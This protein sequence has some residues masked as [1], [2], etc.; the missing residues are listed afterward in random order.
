MKNKLVKILF[1]LSVIAAPLAARASL[2]WVDDFQYANGPVILNSEYTPA[3]G[4]VGTNS[5]WVRDSGS[6]F[7]TSDMFTI[8]SNLQ[9]VSTG[10]AGSIISRQDDCFRLLVQTNWALANAGLPGGSGNYGSYTNNLSQPVQVIY[11]SFTV[12]CATSITNIVFTNSPGDIGSSNAVISGIGLPSRYGSY[13]ASFY[14]TF[15]G[16]CGRIQA[17]TNSTQVPNTW[18]LGVT[19]NTLATNL[20]DGGF[21]VDL[22]VNT[23]YQVVEEFDPNP[24]GTQA[25]TIW[26]N[27]ININQTGLHSV[28]T[29][30]T[31]SDKSNSALTNALNAFAFRQASSF[32]NA[33]F[34][35]TNLATA[36]TFAEAMTN[37]W[38][39]N[40]VPPVVVYQPTAVNSNFVGST[41]SISAVANGQGLANLTYD[42]Q[43]SSS[44][45]NSNPV[46]VSTGTG[47][48]SGYNGNILTLNSAQVADSGYL[49]LV[50]TTPYGLST[51]SSVAKVA[52]TATP[53]PPAFV[54]GGQPASQTAYSG[55]TVIFST[56]VSSPFNNAISY[57][58]Y[59]N[60]VVVSSSDNP[61]PQQSDNGESSTY[62]FN[63]VT[64]NCAALYK[65]AVTNDVYPTGIVSTNAALT[66]LSPQTVSI[67]YLHSLV[68]PVSFSPT[69]SPPSIAYQVSGTVTT[70]TN[71]TSGNTSSYYLQ[72][73]TGGINIF[74]TGGSS[75]RPVQGDVVT[76]IGVLSSYT[77]GLELYADTAD[78]SY[79]YTSYIDTGTTNA[80]PAPIAIPYNFT[81]AFGFAYVNTN[82]AGS[83]V[84]ITDVHFGTNAGVVLS[85]SAN[86]TIIVTNSSGQTATLTFFDLDADTAGQTLPTNAY[87]VTG[88]LYGFQPTFSVGVTRWADIVTNPPPTIIPTSSAH[89]SSFSL[90]NGNVVITGTNAQTTGVYYLLA[91]TNLAMS[92]SQWTVVATNVVNTNGANGAF[93]FTGTNVATPNT[94]NKF[95]ILSNTNSNHP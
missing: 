22:A 17:F 31:A 38:T 77:S 27:P 65:V 74:V 21:P 15:Y 7:P 32:G 87:S 12:I 94:G 84:K 54:A 39:T 41:F 42:W 5:L 9:V 25:A 79:P 95:Y 67:A 73:G 10:V 59:S 43:I 71:I 2:F 90:A 83:L 23:P 49:T 20:P 51:T 37:I 62:T 47:D 29:H 6:A 4:P 36:T 93:T 26:V 66:I 52:I 48:Y 44:P 14:N 13:F 68:D 18:R 92:L 50:V 82:L 35:I 55:Q 69:N 33:T 58:W 16:Y 19:D 64:P 30:Y 24:S 61:S 57:T 53:V 46:D 81:N 86:N 85:T 72:D 70:Y 11:A 56:A 8:N 88:V 78:S 34:L 40:A 60:N 1:A 45:N 89:I 80:L 76:Y 63:S 91:S 3:N 28:D 75:F